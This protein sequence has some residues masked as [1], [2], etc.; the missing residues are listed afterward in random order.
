MKIPNKIKA[1]GRTYIVHRDNDM[2]N[3]LDCWGYVDPYKD[4][5]SI[6]KRDTEFTSGHEKQVL[7]HELIHL[8]DNNFNVGLNENQVQILAVGL[9]TIIGDN[10]LDFT[11]DK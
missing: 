2:T 11:D 3:M 1:F 4:I 8:V 9:S 10:K 7:L 5:I 6:K